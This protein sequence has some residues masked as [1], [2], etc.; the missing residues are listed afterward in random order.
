MN[1]PYLL[2]HLLSEGT[3][4]AFDAPSRHNLSMLGDDWSSSECFRRRFARLTAFCYRLEVPCGCF[5][6]LPPLFTYRMRE[7]CDQESLLWVVVHS[8]FAAKLAAYIL[9]EVYNSF[10]L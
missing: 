3:P 4:V 10:R 7:L 8:E 5:T 9:F 6:E 2:E 1:G